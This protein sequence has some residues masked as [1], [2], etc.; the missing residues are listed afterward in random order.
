MSNSHFNSVVSELSFPTSSPKPRTHLERAQF[1]CTSRLITCFIN[2]DLIKGYYHTLPDNGLRSWCVVPIATNGDIYIISLKNPPVGRRGVYNLEITLL[3]PQDLMF[4]LYNVESGKI[5]PEYDPVSTFRKLSKAAGVER[6]IFEELVPEIESTVMYM[7]HTFANRVPAPTLASSSIDWEQSIIEGHPHHPTHKARCA[8]PP[9]PPIAPGSFEFNTIKLRFVSVPAT[10]MNIRGEF[11]QLMFPLLEYAGFKNIPQDKVII[12]L[13]P[14]QVPNVEARFKDRGINVYPPEFT[15]EARVQ[16]SL[17]TVVLPE[18]LPGYAI[19][20]ACGINITSAMRTITPYTAHL[21][22]GISRDIIP[23]LEI[24]PTVLAVELEP[25]SAWARH[26][27]PNYSKHLSCV[28]RQET[29]EMDQEKQG[30]REIICAALVERDPDANGSE[31]SVLIRRWGLDTREKA[32]QFLKRYANIAFRAFLPPLL[33]NGFAFEAHLQ[34]TKACFDRQTGELKSFR[35]RDFG[36]IKLHQETLELTT[37]RRV[38]VLPG[39]VIEAENAKDTYKL[40]HHTL[41]QCHLQQVVRALQLHADGIGW[42]IVREEFIQQVPRQHPLF[43][44]WLNEEYVL[45]KCLIRMKFD[46]L[47]RDYIYRL[48]PNILLYRPPTDDHINTNQ[49][50]AYVAAESN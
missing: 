30:E 34:N 43:N 10:E 49:D 42:Q 18:I 24:D 22:P 20:L 11:L 26:S 38:E 23:R 27:D 33:K 7:E 9:I 4:P 2:E 36:G 35:I 13:H 46:G 12:P 28:F 41:I 25:G 5:V 37:G 16:A 48:I 29:S 17:R 19:K 15:V 32:M 50:I 44:A 14:L 1:A 31:E 45:G 39:S 3:D 21:G 8:V 40:L 6:K 47:S